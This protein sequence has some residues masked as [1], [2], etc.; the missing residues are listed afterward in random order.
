MQKAKLYA[1][2]DIE[3][4]KE[5]QR[6]WVKNLSPIVEFNLGWIETYIDSQG[7]RAYYEGIVALQNKNLS[8]KYK[9]LVENS[10]YF[11]SQL[12][13]SKD[14]E[15]DK[16]IKPDFTALDIV[17]F[18]TTCIFIGINLPNYLD[19]HETDGFKSL[20]LLNADFCCNSY[21]KNNNF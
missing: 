2:N 9:T 17:G 20:S 5:S 8:I 10:D 19:V 15:K 13:W 21:R 1:S 11:I 14:F 18:P 6:V 7:V 3:K 4:H 16:F 12:P